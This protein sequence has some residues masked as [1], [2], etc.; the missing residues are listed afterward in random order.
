[1]KCSISV[2]IGLIHHFS[3]MCRAVFLRM[4]SLGVLLFTMWGQITCNMDTNS[5]NCE[6]CQYNNINYQVIILLERM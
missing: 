1:M 5:K 3:S 6:Q 2:T 4:V